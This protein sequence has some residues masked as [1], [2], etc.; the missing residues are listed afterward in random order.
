M[1]HRA[2]L[3][4]AEV[5]KFHALAVSSYEEAVVRQGS[6]MLHTKVAGIPI[7][8][9]AAGKELIAAIYPAL[10]GIVVPITAPGAARILVFDTDASGVPAPQFA[11][12]VQHLIR[13]RGDCWTEPAAR[14]RVVF[15][16][17]DHTLQVFDPTTG[18]C[19]VIISGLGKLPPWALAAPLRTPLAM[20]LESRGVYLV[21]GAAMGNS[22][23]A[24]LVTGY[25]GSG[26]STAA[27]SCCKAGMPIL[28]DDYVAIR[29][30]R[31]I[32]D[33]PTVHNV[34]AS[35][36][37]LPKELGEADAGGLTDGK[38]IIYPFS[39]SMGG[40]LRE[41]PLKAVA[42]AKVG[43]VDNGQ[44]VEA[45]PED[46]ARIA[47]A[48]TALQIPMQNEA[49]AAD[50]IL[51]C[52]G[53][54]GAY[55]ITFGTDRASAPVIIST[56]LLEHDGPSAVPLLPAW[57]R[58]GA[59]KPISVVL[60]IHNGSAF[61]CEAVESVVAQGYP[62][63]EIIIVDDG[64][65]DDLNFALL[66][67]SHPFRLIRQPQCGPSAARNS[68]IHK[69]R[70]D[71]I[72]FL[73][74]D[75][76]WPAGSLNSLARDLALHEHAGVVRGSAVTFRNDFETGA[77]V[78]AYHPRENY[79]FYIGGGLYRRS[80]FDVVGFFDETLHYAEDTDWYWRAAEQSLP[81]INVADVV[82]KVRMHDH[83]MTSDEA[84]AKRGYVQ[85]L[86]RRI[87]RCRHPRKNELSVVSNGSS[88]TE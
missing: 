37:V 85:A 42:S 41:A 75:D 56:L 7:D 57:K 48:S 39:S 45:A 40:L 62:E 10:A 68:G 1:K 79:P 55:S 49:L 30:P 12:P 8:I 2:A 59:L 25:G 16:M 50:A 29:P 32:G 52:A 27:L 38:T 70:H 15:H 73:D 87:L 86:K 26:K 81:V 33:H 88:P 61:I 63:I 22:D 66:R 18:V 69:A 28:G 4:S 3:T 21:H 36:K 20:I 13:W 80:A 24:V 23:G 76:I 51:K 35:L 77:H 72:A 9:E 83:N 34:F 74:A 5:E 58:S 78:N 67:I 65:T 60:P 6:F 19:V 11:R 64:S 46:V 71:W 44:I 17:S 14:C 47:L 84:A 82:L 43:N 54:T 53:L 31:S